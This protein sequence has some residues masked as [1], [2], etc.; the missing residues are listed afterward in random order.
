M[1]GYRQFKS[2]CVVFVANIT[3]STPTYKTR[4][5]RS[6][7]CPDNIFHLKWNYQSPELWQ[8]AS[9]NAMNQPSNKSESV[10]ITSLWLICYNFICLFG[11]FYHKCIIYEINSFYCLYFLWFSSF[12][13]HKYYCSFLLLNLGLHSHLIFVMKT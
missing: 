2:F 13:E 10:R 8:N 11:L 7:P 1:K 6:S 12:F 9:S 5:Q 4:H 3:N